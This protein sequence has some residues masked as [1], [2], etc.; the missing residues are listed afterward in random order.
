MAVVDFQGGRIETQNPASAGDG[1]FN[2]LIV[3]HCFLLFS[4]RSTD[5]QRSCQLHNV[6]ALL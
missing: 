5:G 6:A 3:M 4:E 1:S 2:R